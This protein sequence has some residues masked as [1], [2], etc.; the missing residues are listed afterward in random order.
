[1]SKKVL[2]IDDSVTIRKVV[3]M[4]LRKSNYEVAEA[5]DGVEALARLDAETIHL[6]ICDVNMPNMDG[7]TFIRKV[8]EHPQHRT[9]PI[10]MLTT[11]SQ[12]ELK[13]QGIDA[14][15][16]AWMVK[17]FQPDRLMQVV[18]KLLI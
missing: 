6:L 11:E 5:G 7:I 8:R 16:R 18:S 15:A 12:E 13:Q 10:L 17:P 9:I 2:V 1:M 4:A 14:G 3:G